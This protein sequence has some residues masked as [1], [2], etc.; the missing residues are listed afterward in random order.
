M[1]MNSNATVLLL[2]II[3]AAMWVQF[4]APLGIV[5]IIFA[6]TIGSSSNKKK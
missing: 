3:I 5:G 6:L 4:I 2:I 1:F